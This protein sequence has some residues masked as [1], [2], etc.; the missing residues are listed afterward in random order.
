MWTAVLS[1]VRSVQEVQKQNESDGSIVLQAWQKDVAARAQQWQLRWKTADAA[2]I[3]AALT[4]E[5][6]SVS[7]SQAALPLEAGQPLLSL[8]AQL[9]AEVLRL[10]ALS[11]ERMT[12]WDRWMKDMKVNVIPVSKADN[13]A[14]VTEFLYELH[15][16]AGP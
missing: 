5:A 10:Q 8:E 14:E 9:P 6:S 15:K 1:W 12:Q 16:S 11:N 4:A 7:D 13:Y 2:Q 3:N